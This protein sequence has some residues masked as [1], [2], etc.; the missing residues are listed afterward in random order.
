MQK[1]SP[2][3]FGQEIGVVAAS[4]TGELQVTRAVAAWQI[5]HEV[6]TILLRHIWT[7]WLGRLARDGR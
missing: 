1:M 4:A 5:L 6:L 2:V 7:R 3:G